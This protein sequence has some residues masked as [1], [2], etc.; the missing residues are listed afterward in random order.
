MVNKDDPEIV[1]AKQRAKDELPTFVKACRTRLA[2]GRPMFKVGLPL[3][4]EDEDELECLWVEVTEL[5][6]Q[7]SGPVFR[8]RI[9]NVPVRSDLPRKGETVEVPA[10]RVMDWA[11]LDAKGK[12]RGLYLD[13]VLRKRQPG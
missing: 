11:F 1:R 12:L 13:T 4:C 5:L 10:A 6:E 3:E 8:G 9:A 2:E 7:A